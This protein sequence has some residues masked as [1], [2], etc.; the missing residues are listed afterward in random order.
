M[1]LEDVLLASAGIAL[2]K[3]NVVGFSCDICSVTSSGV[4][5]LI[6][7]HGPTIKFILHFLF[8]STHTC[9]EKA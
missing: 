5:K 4:T 7:A 8:V 3:C 1:W 6:S 2:S 9:I